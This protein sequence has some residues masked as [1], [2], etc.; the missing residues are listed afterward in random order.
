MSTLFSGQYLRNHWTLDIGVLGYIG[1]VWPKEHTPEVRSFP[2]G[3]PCIY[4]F[5][6]LLL[7]SIL[8]QN[9]I[10]P[11][12]MGPT[13]CQIIGYCQLSDT[14]FADLSSYRLPDYWIFWIIRWHHYLNP[15]NAKLNPN[16]KSQLAELFCGVFEF[17]AWFSK[18]LNIS[19]TKQDKFMKQ[20]AF[21]GGRKQTL[22]S[23][24]S[25]A[26]ISL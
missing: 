26:V 6:L 9:S 20:K 12:C 5:L 2:P 21:C 15:L 3:T 18:N 1:I 19:R 10:N 14:T 13:R 22:L 24:P 25:N 16:S 23:V 17:C 7:W 8:W 11:A 4:I